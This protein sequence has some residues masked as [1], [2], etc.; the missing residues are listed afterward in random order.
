MAEKA[1][2]LHSARGGRGSAEV[3]LVTDIKT[4]GDRPVVSLY[5]EQTLC[6]RAVWPGIHT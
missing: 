5:Q 6:W 4:W 1:A 2:A 3:S